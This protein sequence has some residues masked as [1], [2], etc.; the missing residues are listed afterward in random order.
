MLRTCYF[1]GLLLVYVTPLFSQQQDSNMAWI[2][3]GEFVMGTN[4]GHAYDHEKPA[5]KVKVAGF[6]MDKTEVTNRQFAAYVNATGYITVAER[7]PDWEEL[8]KQLPANTAKPHDSLLVPG[9]LKFQP[10]CH[11]VSLNNYGQWWSWTP[12]ATCRQM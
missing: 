6:W 9:S 8:K 11:H 5:H 10:P 3:G 4:V 12:G 2:P 7:K 1:I